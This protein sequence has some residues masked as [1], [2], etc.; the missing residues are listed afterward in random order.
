MQFSFTWDQS[1]IQW[2]VWLQVINFEKRLKLAPV[3]TVEFD[4]T[5]VNT[6][7]ADK[8]LNSLH[9]S[10]SQ[11]FANFSR[12]AARGLMT[13]LRSGRSTP[14]QARPGVT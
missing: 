2:L 8:W 14:D 7:S 3:K 5:Q 10:V 6:S 9:K 1:V 12:R 4:A 11:K 13:L